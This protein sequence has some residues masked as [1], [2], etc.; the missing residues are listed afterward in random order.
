LDLF[1]NRL[2]CDT[3]LSEVTS[4][5]GRVEN[6]LQSYLLDV[7]QVRGILPHRYPFLLVD[8]ML[9]MEP[10]KRAV[11]LKNVTVNEEFF[12][13]HFPGH[14]V[15]PGVLLLEA[16]AQVGGV[17]LLSMSGN[18]GKLAYFGGMDKVRFRRPVLPG[19][20]IITEVELLKAHGSVGKVRA[21]SKVDGQIAAEGE[22]MFALVTRER[23][24][25]DSD[26]VAPA[27][28][29]QQNEQ[30]EP[31]R[32]A[33]IHPT[34]FVHPGAEIG[35][36]VEIGPNCIIESDV[37]IGDGTKIEPNVI[38]KQYTTVGREC[39]IGASTVLGGLPQDRKFK[40][41]RSY[42][43]IGDYNTIR[44][45]CSI[46]RASG[47]DESTVIGDYNMIMAYCHVGHN[48]K[49]GSNI[50]IANMVGISGHVVVEDGVVFGGMVGVHQN[51]RIG[52]FAMI[53]G[54]SKVVT[55]VPPFMLADG[56]PSRV[57]DINVVGLRRSGVSP[58]VRAGLR[59]SHKLLYRS[60]LNVSQA[61]EAIEREVE[62]SEELTYLIDFIKNIRCGHHGRQLERPRP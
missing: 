13:G 49:I 19:D 46:H 23:S 40:G 48:C 14:A 43:R 26:V 28:A 57:Y 11:G 29:R 10:G 45:F 50:N 39:V 30:Q 35:E 41:E 15:M 58:K 36:D 38:I 4:V 59:K 27:S 34:S 16:M 56:R 60:N 62:P 55:D 1:I 42:L 51:V 32:K 61:I 21:I 24:A 5:S 25:G 37:R 47:E 22:F 7:E 31:S 3:A 33:L 20:T 12:Q 44:E 53:G 8:R 17:L 54:M 9:E 52:K 2:E 18:A 6:E